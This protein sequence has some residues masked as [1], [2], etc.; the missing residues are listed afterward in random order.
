MS[1]SSRFHAVSWQRGV[2]TVVAAL[3]LWAGAPVAIAQAA[4]GVRVDLQVLLL[5]GGDPG[6]A[7]IATQMDREGVP[8][9]AVD[10]TDAGRPVI[11]DAYLADAQRVKADSRPSCCRIR[12]AASRRPS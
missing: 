10:L 1:L 7:A 11:D 4:T 6:T 2:A 8:Y 9:T 12:P 5:E 3:L